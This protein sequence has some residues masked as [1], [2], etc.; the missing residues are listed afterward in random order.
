MSDIIYQ[1]TD[2][3]AVNKPA[4]LLSVPGRGA[5]K[6]DCLA[7]RVQ[8]QFPTAR[9]VHRLDQPTSGLILMALNEQMQKQLGS[10]F[11]RRQI[12]KKYIAMVD[13]IPAP[14]TGVIDQPLIC[15][16]PNRPKQKIDYAHG[17][18]AITRYQLIKADRR[19]GRA[20]LELFPETGRSHQLR[21]HMLSIGHPILGDTLYTDMDQEERLYLHATEL[22]F[23]HPKTKEKLSL[24]CPAPF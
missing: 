21:V 19:N 9:I 5:D 20:R 8:Q 17:K 7:T 4:G 3:I 11:E 12:T 15:D 1:D 13:G 22:L 16:W 23:R 14:A 2:I 18:S 6:Q 10:L 24:H